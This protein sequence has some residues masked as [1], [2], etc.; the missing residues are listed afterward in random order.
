MK[1]FYGL[2]I[3]ITERLDFGS[4]PVGIVA[5][6]FLET[7]GNAVDRIDNDGDS[8]ELGPL[9]TEDILDGEIA[10]NLIDD[11]GNG[12]IDENQTHIPFGEQEG[13]TYADRIA[14]PIDAQWLNTR[15]RNFEVESGSPTVTQEM[16]NDASGNRWKLWPPVDN[17]QQGQVHLIMVEADDIG[18]AYKDNIDNNDN[19]E[20]GSPTITQAM[21]DQAAGDAPYFRYRVNNK[22]ILY[23]VVQSTLDM[24]YAD[25][26]DNDGNGIV[27]ENIDEGIDVMIDEARDDGIDNDYDWNE[28]RDDVGLDGV[29]GTGDRGEGDGI[30]T[31]GAG[32]GLPGEPNVDL[33]DVSET[34]QIGI[35]NAQKIAAGGLNINSDA[36]M[37]FDFMIPGKFFEPFPVIQ[38]EYDLFV[39]S[40]FFPLKSGQ[41][42]PFSI[43]VMLANG[44]AQDPD[45]ELRK[46]E[47]LRKRVRAQETYN[48]DYQFAQAPL[49][50]TLTA[51]AGDNRVTLYWDDVAEESFDTYIDGIGGDGFDFEGYK[52]YRSTDPAFQDIENITSGFGTPT[53]KTPLVTFDLNNG[54]R[55][56]HPVDL[57][58]VKYHLGTD[59]GLKHSFV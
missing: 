57:D 30:P 41:R 18:Y 53:F 45:G 4:D 31:S 40:S 8:P 42:E 14:Q 24:K 29:D 51:V 22:I 1:I 52:I 7:P 46:A 35:S 47:I 32:T 34:D 26:I 27:D 17:F 20:E 12:L 37:W 44:P 10:D 6:S 19:G 36:T 56:F 39:S 16:I 13:V 21:I 28:F 54:I 48:N 33:T 38:G 59:S 15:A 9:V 5:V 25:G 3:R 11:N 23:N 43:A 58:G 49:T 50:P 2:E 55:D